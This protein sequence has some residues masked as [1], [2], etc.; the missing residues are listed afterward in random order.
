MLAASL[1]A[2]TRDADNQKPALQTLPTVS[3]TV[4]EG[5]LLADAV[6]LRGHLN[7]FDAGMGGHGDRVY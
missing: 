5:R 4:I 7:I 1:A 2:T 3:A 6:P